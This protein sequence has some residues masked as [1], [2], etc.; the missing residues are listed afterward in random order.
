MVIAV[1]P[2]T[3]EPILIPLSDAQQLSAVFSGGANLNT[4]KG[5]TFDSGAMNPARFVLVVSKNI[6]LFVRIFVQTKTTIIFF[7]QMKNHLKSQT[8]GNGSGSL[9]SL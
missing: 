5:R 7:S 8:L 9:W 3:S 1:K 6:V 2:G 4:I